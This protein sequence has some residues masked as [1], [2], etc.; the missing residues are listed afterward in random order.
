MTEDLA[1]KTAGTHIDAEAGADVVRHRPFRGWALQQD[2]RSLIGSDSDV[3]RHSPDLGL[4]ATV[5]AH[6]AEIPGQAFLRDA[7]E[8]DARRSMRTRT[9]I[10]LWAAAL[11][12]DTINQQGPNAI[13]MP[14]GVFTITITCVIVV[15]IFTAVV[16]PRLSNR[17][18]P[19]VEQAVLVFALALI[20][21]QCYHTGG[22]FSPYSVWLVFPVFYVG[23]LR[24]PR[25]A[26]IDVVLAILVACAPLIYDPGS[27]R[28][29]GAIVLG[30]LIIVMLLT[31]ATLLYQRMIERNVERAVNFLALADPMTGV[32][33]LR[34]FEQ[35]IED[36]SAADN[37][38]YALVMADMNGLKGANK[39]FSHEIGDGMVVRLAQLMLAASEPSSQVLRVGGDEFA[40]LIPGGRQADILSWQMRFDA[41]VRAHNSRVRGRLPQI[42]ASIGAATRPDDGISAADLLDAADKRMYAQKSPIVPPPYEVDGPTALGVSR[43]LRDRFA[44]APLSSFEINDRRIHAAAIRTLFGGVILAT[45]LYPS[46][47][48][49]RLG[50]LII[51]AAFVVLAAVSVSGRGADPSIIDKLSGIAAILLVLPAILITGGSESPI[52]VAMIF[53]VAYYAQ[54]L[55]GNEAISRI[56]AIIALYAVGVWA[57]GDVSDA[58]QALF[59]TIVTALIVIAVLLQI[60]AK[61]LDA[62]LEIVRES[63]THDPLTGIRN[64]HAFRGDLALAIESGGQLP[65]ERPG[66]LIADLDD[67]RRVNTMAGHRAGDAILRQAVDHLKVEAG[68]E[69]TVYRIGGDEFAVLFTAVDRVEGEKLA[70][71]CRQCLSFRGSSIDSAGAR[72]SASIGWSIWQ[73]GQSGEELV[74]A[75]EAALKENKAKGGRAREQSSSVLL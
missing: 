41:L 75:V 47:P 29:D 72:V 57:D 61:A 40:V 18:Y 20:G 30:T 34:A 56:G 63:A 58:N 51:G 70:Q 19:R 31:A 3:R 33:N 12:T 15:L 27:I 35:L 7:L 65:V 71:R 26:V 49:D 17:I 48:E 69:S 5:E 53:P 32:A 45:T 39:V 36:Y 8:P 74:E 54:Y 2:L 43:L 4:E 42:S 73:P 14:N 9:S 21:Y 62:S 68:E 55:R 13:P 6:A 44:D 11:L 24:P 16:Y 67:F 60:N 25:Q 22:V 50:S 23:Y 66:L 28:G 38:N 59:A 64:V 46:G 52:Q 1:S 10:A 37:D